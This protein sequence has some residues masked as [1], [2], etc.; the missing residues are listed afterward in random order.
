MAR[1]GPYHAAAFRREGLDP[2]IWGHR[3][4]SADAP[5]NS[6]AAFAE[7]ARQGADGVEC[8]VMLAADGALVVC[9]DEKLDRLAG[10]PLLVRDCPLAVLQSFPLL[11]R[12][13]PTHDERIPT[14]AAAV[15]AGGAGLRWNVELKV[16]RSIDAEPLARALVLALPSLGLQGRLLVSSFHPHALLSLRRFAPE[17][18]TALLWEGKGRAARLLAPLT[19]TAAVH[20]EAKPLALSDVARW[21]ARGYAVNVW[22]VD[23]PADARR[24][25][26]AGVDGLITNRPAALRAALAGY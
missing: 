23:D 14:L 4:A 26:L 22:T 6:P 16:D 15:E 17:V 20:P 13:F 3:G 19:S 10:V 2:S 12:R 25:R 24:L 7:A 21:H 9:H 1:R 11:Q 8:D 5:E 18:P